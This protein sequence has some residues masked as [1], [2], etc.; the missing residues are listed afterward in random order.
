[1]NKEKPIGNDRAFDRILA[2]TLAFFYYWFVV[3]VFL[4]KE[5]AAYHLNEIVEDHAYRIYDEVNT[6]SITFL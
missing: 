1:M 3:V 2:H 6:I 5:Q 4:W